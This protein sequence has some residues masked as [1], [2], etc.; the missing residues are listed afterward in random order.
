MHTPF[1]GNNTPHRPEIKT[2]FV[3][4]SQALTPLINP[5]SMV[6]P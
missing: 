3:G 5:Q 6:L 1:S 2:F 4:I